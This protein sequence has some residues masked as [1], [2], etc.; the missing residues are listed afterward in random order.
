MDHNAVWLRHLRQRFPRM[1]RLAAGLFPGRGS[2]ALRGRFLIAIGRR[3]FGR[4][5]TV[6]GELLFESLD[7]VFKRFDFL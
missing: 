6:F 3:R 5:G 4:V 2:E 1:A 7:T